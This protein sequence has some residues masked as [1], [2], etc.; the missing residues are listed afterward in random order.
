VAKKHVRKSLPSLAIKKMQ[1]K[2]TLKFY[3][4]SVRI[5]TIKNTTNNKCCQG[6]RQKG[7]LK[8][9]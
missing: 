2:T 8:H 9:C 3:L 5:T 4:T 1:M 7:A 6:C